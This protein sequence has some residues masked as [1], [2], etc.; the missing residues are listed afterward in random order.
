M[1][2]TIWKPTP[3]NKTQ[4]ENYQKYNSTISKKPYIIKPNGSMGKE[5]KTSFQLI[6]TK[7]FLT[8]ELSTEG[9]FHR[10]SQFHYHK[11]K[12]DQMWQDKP[13]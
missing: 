5:I 4:F 9:I 11:L 12:V 1:E 8:T 13:E 6:V 3:P 7:L 2:P 10:S